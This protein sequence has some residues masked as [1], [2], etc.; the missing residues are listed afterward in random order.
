VIQESLLESGMLEWVEPDAVLNSAI[1]E[2]MML[3]A[4]ELDAAVD[5][6]VGC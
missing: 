4:V 6:G 1:Q 2:S 5:E 3:E